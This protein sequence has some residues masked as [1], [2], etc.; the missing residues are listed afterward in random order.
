MKSM[1]N[2]NANSHR[3]F[4]I[5]HIPMDMARIV[6]AVLVPIMRI[7]RIK[8]DGEKYTQKIK[9]G[10]I[11][12]ANHTSFADPFIVGVTFWYRRLFFLVAEVVMNGRLRSALLRGVGAIKIDRQTT[13]IEAINS[14]IKVLKQQYLLAVFPQGG[15]NKND[16]VDAV[17]SGAVL[18]AMRAGVPIIPMH[19]SKSK[20]WY[21]KKTVV[22]GNA[23]DPKEYCKK[24]MPTTADIQ[25]ITDALANELNICK[26][27]DT[28]FAS[29]KGK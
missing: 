9:G 22:I 5:R 20:H 19:I 15:I 16:D 11:I 12:A 25:N 24:I 27:A 10:A 18:M 23:I 8:P 7:K 6:C 29:H 1:K 14:S 3:F 26:T 17:K 13:D 21:N 28:K 2:K 4:S